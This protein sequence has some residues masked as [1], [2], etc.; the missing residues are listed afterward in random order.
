LFPYAT[1]FNLDIYAIDVKQRGGGLSE[2]L[3]R[4]I[5]GAVVGQ[6]EDWTNKTILDVLRHVRSATATQISYI[7]GQPEFQGTPWE[8]STQLLP[9]KRDGTVDQPHASVPVK[10]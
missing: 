7:E 10:P 2:R 4:A 3:G 1:G 8:A 6:P 9:A 5:A